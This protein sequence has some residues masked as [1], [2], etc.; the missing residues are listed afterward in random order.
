MTGEN[1]VNND[2]GVYNPRDEPATTETLNNIGP[3]VARDHALD[4]AHAQ[5]KNT[6]VHTHAH[7]S[8][9]TVCNAAALP[10]PML[11]Q[12]KPPAKLMFMY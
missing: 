4:A 7:S 10:P 8:A 2:V 1:V 6:I 9:N 5:T 11:E 3:D 12:K